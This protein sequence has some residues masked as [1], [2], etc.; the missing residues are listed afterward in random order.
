MSGDILPLI[1]TQHIRRTDVKLRLARKPDHSQF[2]P[3]EIVEN[4]IMLHDIFKLDE[5]YTKERD[6]R[7]D[8]EADE[9][10][11]RLHQVQQRFSIF[12]ARSIL[13]YVG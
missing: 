9:I 4:D 7:L 13:K 10:V 5:S 8:A 2:V 1:S 11:V 3:C 12:A 6:L